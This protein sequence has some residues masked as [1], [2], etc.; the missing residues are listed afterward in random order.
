M[1]TRIQL[2]LGLSLVILACSA[3]CAQAQTTTQTPVP[4]VNI[5]I[6]RETVRFV[7][8]GEL[9]QQWRL[10]VFHQSGELIFDSGLLTAP[11]LDWPL[12]NQQGQAVEDGL[13][14]YRLTIKDQAGETGQ[15]RRGQVII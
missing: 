5:I 11:S 8:P 2:H 13:Y 9:P 4:E 10:E 1:F 6:N 14:A 12:L 3:L 15:T 7:T